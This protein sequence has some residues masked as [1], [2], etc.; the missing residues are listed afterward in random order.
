M[1]ISTKK[2]RVVFIICSMLLSAQIIK[3]QFK[4]DV[5][6][7]VVVT[8]YNDVRIPGSTGTFISFPDDLGSSPGLFARI[9]FGYK[10]GEGSEILA[11]YAPLTVKY[12]GEIDSDVE[13]FG[14]TFPSATPILATY[15]FNS[16]RATY[17]YNLL[18]RENINI[19]LGLTIKVRDA[20]IG[21]QQ[22]NLDAKKTDFGAV[23][24]INFGVYWQPADNIGV[25][26][27]GDALAAH[28]G[29]AEDVLL[30]FNYDVSDIITL[31]AGYRILEGGADIEKLYT[32]SMFHY[33]VIGAVVNLPTR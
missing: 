28:S 22:G 12:E 4:L 9:T 8:G 24:L 20:F 23:P 1:I 29:R 15:K 18:C 3:A 27:E 19:A 33:G 16:Y 6:T 2:L 13:F 21:L 11:L 26:L 17:R 32:F 7:G 31:K 30:A 14:K 5:E 25:T 10:F